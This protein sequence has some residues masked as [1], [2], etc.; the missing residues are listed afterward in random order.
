MIWDFFLNW[1]PPALQRSLREVKQKIALHRYMRNSSRA[2]SPGYFAFKRY[3][4]SQTLADPELLQRF[5][6][7]SPL[8]AG[9]GKGLDE[10]CVEYPWLFSQMDSRPEILLDAGSTLN[11]EYLLKQSL[12]HSK[13]LHILTLA[14]EQ[15]CFWQ[16]GISYIY[17][18]LRDIPSKAELYDTIVCISTLEHIG[19]DNTEFTGKK[20][21]PENAPKDFLRVMQEFYRLLKSGGRLLLTVPFGKYR[22]FGNQQQFDEELLR[23]AISAFGRFA[24]CETT[25]F[26]YSRDGWQFSEISACRDCE[27][28]A[29]AAKRPIPRP[30]PVEPDLATAARA[31]ACLR[32]VK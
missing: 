1:L 30:V 2:F 24:S 13:N 32:L 22:H 4:I 9:Y 5:R 15:E 28:V 7:G 17:G 11:Q 12:L 8:P 19:C 3:L 16:R 10:R 14:P 31:V 21:H 26:R 27:Y 23:D 29:W 18:D 20:E 6:S 25:F